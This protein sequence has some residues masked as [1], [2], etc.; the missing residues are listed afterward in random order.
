MYKLNYFNFKEKQGNYLIT[1]DIGKFVFLS[2]QNFK[3]LI[4]K[5]ELDNE[6]KVELIKKGFIY[7]SNEELFAM[8]QAMQLRNTK[9]Y[10]L[11]ATTLHIFV[12]S[13]NC[14]FN[15]I[16]CQ[17]GN[18]NQN[19]TYNMSKETAKRAVDI[20]MDS[21]S[22]YLT[23]EFQGGEPLMNFEIIKYIIEY[24]K[25]ISNDKFIE[26]NLVSNLT[27][28]TNEMIDFFIKN[29]VSICT[30]I[31]GNKELQNINR[32]YK[33][34]DSFV[35]TVNQIN[36]LKERNIK[37][38][39]IETTTKY[40]LNKYKE[41]VDEYIEL[42]L[43][44]IFIRPLTRLGKAD[45]NWQKIGYTAEEFLKFYKSAL[46]YIIDKNREGIFLSEGH[47]NIFLK[48]ILLNQPVNYMEL[49]SPCGGAIGQL[50]Y[51]YDGNIY[52]CDEGRML[53]EMGDDSFKLGNVYEN[54][55]KELMQCDCTKAMCIS[56]CLECLPYCS[57]CAYMPFC[58]TCPVINLAQDNNIFSKAPKE[59]R[60]KIYSGIL[61]ILFDYIE[62][63]SETVEIFKKW[64][65]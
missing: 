18:L 16:Y 5:K 10:M 59:Y 46:D 44:S 7:D 55:Y 30:S 42:G 8:N 57:T 53:S 4:Q 36:K 61:D 9:E 47:S 34:A 2:K 23:F 6:L 60:C 41:I 15:C 12:V 14:N 29:N 19:K 54:T 64:I 37:V 1:N 35:E 3:N 65:M 50:A 45:N 20:A 11:T 40:S 21:P 22:K 31:D 49:R 43:E 38:N 48:K 25:S 39:A 63:K 28:L 13:K 62:N 27:L 17:A 24:S 33:N 26:Y 51:Y 58:G 52:T 56:S 32:P